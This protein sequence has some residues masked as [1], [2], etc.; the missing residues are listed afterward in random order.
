VTFPRLRRRTLI[1]CTSDRD[2]LN[3]KMHK[4]LT[5]LERLGLSVRALD[6]KKLL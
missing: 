3:G 5:L 4:S 2:G 6:G 1:F